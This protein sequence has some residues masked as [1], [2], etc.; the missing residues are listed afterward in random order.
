MGASMTEFLLG[1]YLIIALFATCMTYFE[2]QDTGHR[3]VL[4]RVLGFVAC[5]LWPVT[6]ITVAIKVRRTAS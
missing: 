3:S 5:A 4:F 6:L 2:Q 1:L